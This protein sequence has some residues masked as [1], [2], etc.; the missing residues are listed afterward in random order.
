MKN[1]SKKSV[2]QNAWVAFRKGQ[3]TFA[4][5]L[6]NAWTN[7]KIETLQIWVDGC[8]ASGSRFSFYKEEAFMI[9][10]LKKTLVRAEVVEVATEENDSIDF[11]M[12]NY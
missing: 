4:Q 1:L 3:L 6:K 9:N 12:F 8:K 11:A 7:I 5:C 10:D 2:M